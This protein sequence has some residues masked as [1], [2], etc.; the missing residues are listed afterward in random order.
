MNIIL[1]YYHYQTS[2]TIAGVNTLCNRR[3]ELTRRCS[4][5]AERNMLS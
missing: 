4:T 1:S 2:L 3:E 5:C